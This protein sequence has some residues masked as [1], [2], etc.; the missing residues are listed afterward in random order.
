MN[1]IGFR[2]NFLIKSLDKIPITYQ[3]GSGKYFSNIKNVHGF[4]SEALKSKIMQN[5]GLCLIL[6]SISWL[7]LTNIPGKMARIDGNYMIASRGKH[8]LKT[9]K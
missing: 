4:G 7:I 6:D 1:L 9:Q 5:V 2:K 8:I 3:I